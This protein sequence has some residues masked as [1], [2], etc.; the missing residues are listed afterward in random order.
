MDC[1]VRVLAEANKTRRETE[2]GRVRPVSTA[3][4]VYISVISECQKVQYYRSCFQLGP[5]TW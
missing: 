1:A 5:W 3:V 2:Q 4:G